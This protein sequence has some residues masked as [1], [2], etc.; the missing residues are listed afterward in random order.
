MFNKKINVEERNIPFSGFVARLWVGMNAKPEKQ[1]Q[2]T[3]G[4]LHPP[5]PGPDLCA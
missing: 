4:P 3:T 1:S 5:T 2:V